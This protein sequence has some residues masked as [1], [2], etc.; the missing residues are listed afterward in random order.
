MLKT[1]IC[2]IKFENPLILAA[3]V[4][5]SNASSLNWILD[6]GAGGI[7][8]KSF[9]K[10]PN[11]GYKNPTTVAVEGGII[12]AIG[13]SSPGVNNFKEELKLINKTNAN[14][15]SNVVIGSIYGSSPEEFSY[16]VKEIENF[17]D[18]IELNVSCPHAMSG[19]GAAIGQDP[20]LTYEIVKACQKAKTTNIPIIAKLTPNVTDLIEIATSA[21]KGGADGLTLINSLGPGMKIDINAKVPI[22]SNKFGGMSGPAIKPIAIRCVY[23]AYINCNIPIIGVGGISNY[24]DV[25]E[26]LYA[27]ASAIQIGTSIMY[28]GVEVF[29][30]ISNDLEEFMKKNQFESI[31]E[32]TGYAHK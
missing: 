26:F 17:V 25:V 9:S 10:E 12:N 5:G 27:G 1:Q 3:G 4:M 22:L 15:E 21:E 32:M 8:T 6:S 11:T 24:E 19:C 30:K 29:S 2:G 18:M 16:L 31:D 13:L 23:D 7:V 14:G 20:N 28:E